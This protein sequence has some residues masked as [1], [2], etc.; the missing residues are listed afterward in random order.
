VWSPAAPGI[1]RSI[2]YETR[3]I[4]DRHL[5]VTAPYCHDCTTALSPFCFVM[6]LS[7][8]GLRRSTVVMLERLSLISRRYQSSLSYHGTWWVYIPAVLRKADNHAFLNLK[9]RPHSQPVLWGYTASPSSSSL[10][11]PHSAVESS[12]IEVNQPRTGRSARVILTAGKERRSNL[13][14]SSHPSSLKLCK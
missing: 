7:I 11:V 14:L 5:F 8:S 2:S 10:C 12:G 13:P 6:S 1:D 9:P 3:S 4:S